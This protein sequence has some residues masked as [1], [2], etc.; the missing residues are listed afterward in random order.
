MGGR[1]P[2]SFWTAYFVFLGLEELFD[3]SEI[4]WLGWW[5]RQYETHARVDVPH[6]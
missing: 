5:A 3:V 1:W 4:W 2:A 6:F